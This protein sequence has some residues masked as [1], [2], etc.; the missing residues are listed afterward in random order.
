MKWFLP[1]LGFVFVGELF[2]YYQWHVLK[3]ST[4]RANYLIGIIESIFYGYIFYQL[5]NQKIVKRGISF[6]VPLSVLGYCIT[7]LVDSKS[8]AYFFNN[9]IISG[10]FIATFALIS[11][12]IKFTDDEE[13]LL[14]SE[15]I[16]WIAVG[17]SLFYSGVS[18]TFSLRD[19]IYENNLSIF[20][21]KLYHSVPE[22]LSMVLYTSISIALFLCRQKNKI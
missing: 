16:F 6:F 21:M 13:I 20:G 1:F 5:N 7:Y 10:F 17:V 15:P 22:L 4:I 8:P 14:I 3:E 12:Y 2:Q 18:I 19:F 9:L 11:L